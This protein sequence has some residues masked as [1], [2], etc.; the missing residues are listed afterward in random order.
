MLAAEALRLAAVE[1]LLPT[2]AQGI[3][4]YPT[5]AG[6]RVFDS[7]EAALE[8]LDQSGPYTPVLSLYTI[9]SSAELRGPH[10]AAGDTEAEAV[11]EIIAQLAV[12]ATE[13]GET[14]V[15]A[16][17]GD[18]PEARLVLAAL[19]AQV[20]RALERSQAGGLWR[21]LV[22][23][24]TKL[25]YETFALPQVGLRWLRVKITVE[26]SI[27]DDC[28]DMEAGGLPEPIKSLFEALP[29]E[30]YAKAKLAALA[31]HFAPEP[32]PALEEVSGTIGPVEA[33]QN[34]LS[35]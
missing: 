19:C 33:G 26:C 3:G 20:R 27:R 31:A 16:M 32:L 6:S 28:Y 21:R 15:D 5:L 22:R 12:S 18:D 35:P 30:S 8:D 1:I 4:P 14:F 34:N 10:A 23:Q 24:I 11:L 25:K 9:E 17:A 2:A 7:R 29:D 13:N